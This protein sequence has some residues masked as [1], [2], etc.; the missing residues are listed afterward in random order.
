M[1]IRLVCFAIAVFASHIG[2][3]ECENYSILLS[4]LA[5][6]KGSEKC[7]TVDQP[8]TEKAD[9][10]SSVSKIL[11]KFASSLTTQKNQTST[12]T[13]QATTGGNNNGGNSSI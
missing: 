10:L 9:L 7:S 1:K 5:P 12:A 4:K 2:Q 13:V 8:K 11:Q 3:S 6:S